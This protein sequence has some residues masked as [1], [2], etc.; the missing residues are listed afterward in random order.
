MRRPEDVPLSD[1]DLLEAARGTTWYFVDY[2]RGV[3]PIIPMQDVP[4]LPRTLHGDRFVQLAEGYHDRAMVDRVVDGHRDL[5]TMPPTTLLS[6][7]HSGAL[8]HADAVGK[9]LLEESH[10]GV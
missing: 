9:S 2:I 4:N 8:K 3:G 10:P 1:D 7:N 5:S 6:A